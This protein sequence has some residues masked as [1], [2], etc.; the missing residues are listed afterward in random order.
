MTGVTNQIPTSTWRPKCIGL[1]ESSV[2]NQIG[3]SAVK[4][5]HA[6]K[7]EQNTCKATV[8]VP[9]CVR[10]GHENVHLSANHSS[11]FLS[12]DSLRAVHAE[13]AHVQGLRRYVC[14]RK[15]CDFDPTCT[16]FRD[17]RGCLLST[18]GPT[19]STSPSTPSFTT[20]PARLWGWSPATRRPSAN[21]STVIPHTAQTRSRKWDK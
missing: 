14:V 3:D 19:C 12:C 2:N 15:K 7:Q 6:I 18:V 9:E 16:S 13:I 20:T 5:E 1:D 11:A 10:F 21:R 4:T 8:K 17:S